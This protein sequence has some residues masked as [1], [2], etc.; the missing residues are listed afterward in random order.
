MNS[1]GIRPVHEVVWWQK[2]VLASVCHTE[3]DDFMSHLLSLPAL[4][5]PCV[6]TSHRWEDWSSKG[7]RTS[8]VQDQRAG[9][10]ESRSLWLQHLYFLP[11]WP[12]IPH[13]KVPQ[14]I[15]TICLIWL[16]IWFLKDPVKCLS[17][18]HSRKIYVLL[19]FCSWLIHQIS[20]W[21]TH[22]RCNWMTALQRD[23][24]LP[25]IS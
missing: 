6:L 17:G 10:S 5:A 25:A 18:G 20:E 14:E 11:H 3:L 13:L 7:M 21:Q 2:A 23:W 19:H 9:K 4:Q 24:Q 15:F 16:L 12:F 1:D 22:L 8:L